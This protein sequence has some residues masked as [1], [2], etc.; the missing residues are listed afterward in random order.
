MFTPHTYNAIS[1]LITMLN[2]LPEGNPVL[3]FILSNLK[4]PIQISATLVDGKVVSI[5]QYTLSNVYS[6]P[7]E[8]LRTCATGG[9]YVFQHTSL[10]FPQYIGSS[11]HLAI[12]LAGHL[13]QLS[14]SLPPFKFHDFVNINGG[15]D[16]L[17]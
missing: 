16:S 15:L 6:V 5:A 7:M 11:N 8:I 1:T 17:T 10:D 12:R 3:E 13:S 14:G 9:T 2:S 4:Q